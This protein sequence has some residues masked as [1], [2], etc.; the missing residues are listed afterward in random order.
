MSTIEK[1]NSHTNNS[2]VNENRL[3]DEY[4]FENFMVGR[5]NKLAHAAALA[6]A[7]VGIKKPYNPLII[8]GNPGLGKTH[9]LYAIRH[10]VEVNHPHCKVILVKCEDFIDEMVSA[11]KKG[12]L[13]GFRERYQTV[14]ML[15]IDDFNLL[16]GNKAIQNEFLT[17]FIT[18]YEH[19]KQVVIASCT[20]PDELT[21]PYFEP[22]LFAR[23]ACGMIAEIQPLTSTLCV[24]IVRSKV[25]L[26]GVILP[27]DVTNYI[28]ENF[29][30]SGRL[31]EGAV[32]IIISYRDIMDEEITIESVKDHLRHLLE[33]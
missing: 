33:G 15:I 20:S 26:L 1:Q 4:T 17:M 6:V 9:L 5:S 19:G 25:E 14:D 24:E 28:A 12:E 2:G 23:F 32:K 18:L 8:Y 22:S 10:Y 27:D 31:L 7:K 21:L 13:D 16:V 3:I 29:S 30:S 11:I